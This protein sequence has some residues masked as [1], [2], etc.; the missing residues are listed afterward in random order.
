MAGIVEYVAR[1][2]PKQSEIVVALQ[3]RIVDGDLRPGTEVSSLLELAQLHK[4]STRTVQRAMHHLRRP[5]GVY[6]VGARRRQPRF[7]GTAAPV[8]LLDL[9]LS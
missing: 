2:S 1:H 9:T 4:A 7:R 6:P 8:Q 3:K 5:G